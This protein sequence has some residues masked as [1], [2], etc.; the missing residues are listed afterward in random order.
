MHGWIPAP[1]SAR[2]VRDAPPPNNAA[3]IA[4]EDT[5]ETTT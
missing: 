1:F 5:E 4:R 3:Q 2:V